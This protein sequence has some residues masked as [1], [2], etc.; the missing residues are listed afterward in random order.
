MGELLKQGGGK[1]G[2]LLKMSI[3]SEIHFVFTFFC[4]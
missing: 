4:V 2:E 1:M 3:N